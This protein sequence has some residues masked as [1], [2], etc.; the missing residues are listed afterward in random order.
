MGTIP[1]VISRK[2]AVSESLLLL[3]WQDRLQDRAPGTVQEINTLGEFY[4]KDACRQMRSLRVKSTHW[5]KY[6]R[7]CALKHEAMPVCWFASRPQKNR[8]MVL[9]FLSVDMFLSLDTLLISLGNPREAWTYSGSLC[10]L[11]STCHVTGASRAFS[12]SQI[13]LCL[14]ALPAHRV[15]RPY[16]APR[17]LVAV[18]TGHTACKE[19]GQTCRS[20]QLHTV[21]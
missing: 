9:C 4:F 18:F 21:L 13:V 6:M 3:N 5:C 19:A 20:S 10:P 16:R 14:F 11:P 7:G 8:A 12:L 17:R 2:R 15:W 1:D